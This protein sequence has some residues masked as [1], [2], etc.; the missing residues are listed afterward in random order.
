MDILSIK[1]T[2]AATSDVQAL[3]KDFLE[4][5]MELVMVDGEWTVPR[6]RVTTEFIATK[7]DRPIEEAALLR[8]ELVNQGY[9]DESGKPL[10]PAMALAGDKGLP[11]ISRSEVDVVVNNL[12]V[13]ARKLNSRP[14]ARIFVERIEIFGSCL[15]DQPDYGDVDVLATLTP[16]TAFTPEE[17]EEEHLAYS[18]LQDVSPYVSMTDQ[19]D[20]V[21][22]NA[23]KAVIFD[24]SK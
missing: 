12:V 8:A 9:I 15:R 7:L 17:G 24:R 20:H 19:F 10:A 1:F 13:A 22:A 18:T 4:I 5:P 14:G 2:H 11:R 6:K 16:P 23:D 3:I 21:A